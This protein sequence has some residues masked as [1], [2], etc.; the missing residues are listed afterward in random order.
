MSHMRI[1]LKGKMQ[2]MEHDG[3]GRS[4]NLLLSDNNIRKG[5]VHK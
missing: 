4:G 5:L 3:G 2:L 1:L